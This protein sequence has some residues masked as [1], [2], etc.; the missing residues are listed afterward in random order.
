MVDIEKLKVGDKVRLIKSINSWS[1]RYF[2]KG[3]E[4]E[5]IGFPFNY[6]QINTDK[7]DFYMPIHPDHFANFEKVEDKTWYKKLKVGDKVRCISNKR[8][9]AKYGTIGKVYKVHKFCLGDPIIEDNT[10]EWGLGSP[11]HEDFEPVENTGTIYIKNDGHTGI[12]N[13]NPTAKL[14]ITNGDEKMEDITKFKKKNLKEAK[15]QALRDKNDYE[16]RVAKDRYESLI[17]QRDSYEREIAIVTESLDK[18]K[19]E[20]AEFD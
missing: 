4:Y 13:N 15:K 5:V 10:G 20:L 12:E 11:Y 2:T 14:F 16:T 19:A 7:Y 8:I 17:D 1:D 18:V 9:S 3:K 6:F